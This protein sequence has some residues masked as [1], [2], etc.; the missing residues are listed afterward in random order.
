MKKKEYKAPVLEEI[1]IYSDK[2]SYFGLLACGCGC[3]SQRVS[4]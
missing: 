4:P 1:E 2:D 3:S